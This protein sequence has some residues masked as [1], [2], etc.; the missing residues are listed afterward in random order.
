ML[1]YG[2]RDVFGR[3]IG[4]STNILSAPSLLDGILTT[5]AITGWPQRDCARVA[6]AHAVSALIRSTASQSR[7]ETTL[8]QVSSGASQ[9]DILWIR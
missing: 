6:N 9:L 4:S 5:S 2:G 7:G 8:R 3:H 1:Q